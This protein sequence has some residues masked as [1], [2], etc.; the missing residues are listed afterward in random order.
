MVRPPRPNSSSRLPGAPDELQQHRS[1]QNDWDIGDH[2]RC[3]LRQRFTVVID[4][5]SRFAASRVERCAAVL[6][7]LGDASPLKLGQSREDMQLKSP[8][9]RRAVD[10]LPERNERHA[11]SVELI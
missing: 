10:A 7:P 1:K 11:E 8:R 2:H 3:P 4:T 6:D 9:R 5:P